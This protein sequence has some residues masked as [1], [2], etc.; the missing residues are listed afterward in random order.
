MAVRRILAGAVVALVVL[1]GVTGTIRA[2]PS[3][4]S[5]WHEGRGN[6]LADNG[7]YTQALAEYDKAIG[8]DPAATYRL[9]GLRARVHTSMGAYDTAVDECSQAL[10]TQPKQEW[11]YEVRAIAYLGAGQYAAAIAD[12]DNATR[13]RATFMDPYFIRANSYAALHQDDR[14]IADFTNAIVLCS[15]PLRARAYEGRGMV[16][17]EQKLYDKALGDFTAA[18]RL[19]PREPNPYYDRALMYA[20]LGDKARA[21]ADFQKYISLAT[22]AQ[23]IEQARQQIAELSK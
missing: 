11:L 2:A 1:L 14:A 23:L 15:S 8:L 12:C 7:L 10:A 21:I 3:F 19:T 5:E 18:I 20:A 16:Y 17:G 6:F 4:L 9:L 13:L 22:D